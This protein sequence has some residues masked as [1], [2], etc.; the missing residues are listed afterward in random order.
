MIL[1]MCI[2]GCNPVNK[3]TKKEDPLANEQTDNAKD[4]PRTE[5]P[6]E[7]EHTYATE[8]SIDD[9]YH[10]Y[11]ATCEHKDLTRGKLKHNFNQW[12]VE[13][14]PTPTSEGFRTRKCYTCGYTQKETIARLIIHGLD[15]ED[16]YSVDE[17]LDIMSEYGAGDISDKPYYVSGVVAEATYNEQYDSYTIYFADHGKNSMMPFSFYSGVI[18]SSIVDG[19]TYSA[20]S[21]VGTTITIYGYLYKYLPTSA[22]KCTYEVGYLS[23]SISPTGQAYTPT[24]VRT[25]VTPAHVHTYETTW[26]YD[27]TSHW[28]AATCG[29]IDSQKDLADH[30]YGNWIVD[31]E[32]TTQSVGCKH[33]NC[34]VC[35]YS[36]KE[37][38]AKLTEG[39]ASGTFTLYT[40]NDFHGAVQEYSSLRHVGLAKFGTYLKQVKGG[41]TMII[42][43][44]D[45]FQGSIESN[46]N[47]GNMVA[48]V[49]NYA[50]VDVHTIGN[51]DFDWGID[52]LIANRNRKYGG[53]NGFSSTYLGANIY[54]YN[55]YFKV[56]GKTFQSQ[57]ADPYYIKT[58]DNGIKVGVVGVIPKE[59]ITDICSPLVEDICFQE[60]ISSI[61]ETAVT[62]R[63]DFNCDIVIASM[64]SSTSDALDY[65]LTSTNTATGKRYV[66]Y[67]CCAHS[68]Q[69]QCTTENG[70]YFTQAACYGEMLYKSTFTVSNG[71]ISNVSVSKLDYSTITS[72][73]KTIDSKVSSIIAD[74]A[75]DYASIGSQVVASSTS[76]TFYKGEQAS[77]LLAKAAYMEA[78]NEGY[79]PQI[80]LNNTG[81]Y[82]LV[83]TSWTYADVYETFPFDNILYVVKVKGTKNIRQLCNSY[84]NCYHASNFTTVNTSTWYTA[85]VID[86]LLFH[87]NSSRSYDY[88]D[89]SSSN[90]QILGT[91]KKNNENYLYRDVFADYV[92]T[93]NG[94]LYASD[95]DSEGEFAHPTYSTY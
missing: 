11:A 30:D 88:Y 70:V 50:G 38:I 63:R 72:A 6:V 24:I 46:Y 28:Y 82:N 58:L 20:S 85:V 90:M 9:E 47:N 29:H 55:F 14:S 43:S 23:A 17:V 57:I 83:G 44:G 76:G 1:S 89:H 51:H 77:N 42:D 2:G 22:Y 48:D 65:G 25:T 86:F 45:T 15:I 18:D 36:E 41:N 39:K 10:W 81:R 21:F 93:L 3:D 80:A 69:D 53:E 91:L 8:Y 34:S 62:L 26:S 92:K 37:E 79:T 35:G 75:K 32:P 78:Q 84:N 87:V 95:Y 19:G 56:E 73:T 12:T 16:P 68:H 27:E 7:H 71:E 31:Q 49:F 60:H 52:K 94:T 54:D 67:V 13:S 66:D 40:F 74:Y 4:D 64:H 59:Q 61:K 33:R 5:E